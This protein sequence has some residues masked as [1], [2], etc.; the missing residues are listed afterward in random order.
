[1]K[2]IVFILFILFVFKQGI[3]CTTAIISGK[4]T[5]NG[6]PMIWKLRDTEST[7]NK[8]MFF[9][10][11]KYQY[12]GLVNTSDSL[13]LQVWGGA[14]SVGFAIMNSASFNVNE[15]DTSSLK[16]QE[17]YFMKLALKNC[18]TLA[19][20]ENLLKTK[21]K[22]MGLA[23][24][25]GVLDAEGGVAFYE[26]NNY[27]F[28]KFDA[29]DPTVAPN[30]YI[31]RTNFSFTGKK[32]KGYGF[33]RYQTAQELFALADAKS[34]LT[35]KNIMQNFSR[36]FKH[37]LLDTDF[38]KIYENM[39]AGNYFIN[40]G[41][42]ITRHGSASNILIQGVKKGQTPNLT[43]VWVQ[44]GYP[45]TCVSIPIWVMAKKH[46]PKIVSANKKGYAPLN[47]IALE[48]KEQCYP[49]K[50]SSGYKYLCIS[51]L[52]NSK[53]T[54]YVQQIEQFENQIFAKTKE[55]IKKWEQQ[56]PTITEINEFYK[57]LDN[58]TI[59]FYK[60]KLDVKITEN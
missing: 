29:N 9:N 17:G 26:V 10:D 52:L 19:D 34:D 58:E 43:T 22:P 59:K 16:D 54:G 23:A 20:F 12:V 5:A 1:M 60:E 49:V 37:S 21:E 4:Y 51:K 2:K 30:G 31:L 36:C 47:K 44:V 33:I 45:N 8:M 15:N 35:V 55:K 24:H 48:L 11:G 40:S 6:K 14:N 28:T 7:K 27:T 56:K 50:R 38:R 46:L 25:F 41:D 57:W 42:F 3:S 32:D 53:Q 13:G 39:P 18:K